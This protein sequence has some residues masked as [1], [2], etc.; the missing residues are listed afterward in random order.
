MPK[1]TQRPKERP[2]HRCV[3]GSAMAEGMKFTNIAHAGDEADEPAR[4][5]ARCWT[6][7]NGVVVHVFRD[8]ETVLSG[9]DQPVSVT[10]EEAVAQLNYLAGVKNVGGVLEEGHR[11][12][13]PGARE[14]YV[15]GYVP[16]GDLL[17]VVLTE[18]QSTL[19]MEN[20]ILAERRD[21]DKPA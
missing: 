7:G 17:G 8:S 9:D 10:P 18:L 14:V 5:W 11:S 21:S 2:A 1:L 20:V 12:V 16:I 3:E 19:G 15:T 13:I 4:T 6:S